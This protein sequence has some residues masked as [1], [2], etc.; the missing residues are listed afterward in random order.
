MLDAAV[1]AMRQMKLRSTNLSKISNSYHYLTSH[2]ENDG[3]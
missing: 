1:A 3:T 2:F